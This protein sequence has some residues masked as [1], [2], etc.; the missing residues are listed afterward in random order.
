MNP[1]MKMRAA[2]K[3]FGRN[4]IRPCSGSENC[5]MPSESVADIRNIRMSTQNSTLPRISESAALMLARARMPVM[6]MRLHIASSPIFFMTV[7]DALRNTIAM[8]R[9]TAKTMIAGISFS[10]N[11]N[12][13]SRMFSKDLVKSSA[14]VAS[15]SGVIS[16]PGKFMGDSGLRGLRASYHLGEEGRGQPRSAADFRP[17][18]R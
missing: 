15:N 3:I 13:F 18:D 11:R 14:M 9:P 4:P 17:T 16:P 2:V 5:G 10:T 12:A 6:P 7:I 1:A 8:S